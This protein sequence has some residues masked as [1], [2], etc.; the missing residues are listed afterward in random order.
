MNIVATESK[1]Q[2]NTYAQALRRRWQRVSLR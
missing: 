1:P 2:M